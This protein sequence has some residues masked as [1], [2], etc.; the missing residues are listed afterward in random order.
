MRPIYTSVGL[1]G[2]SP[3]VPINYQEYR[4]GFNTSLGAVLTTGASLTYTVQHTYDDPNRHYHVLVSRSG[5]TA[6]MIAT[7][8]G[9][10]AGDSIIVGAGGAP[11][12][13]TFTVASVID[14][15]TLTYTVSNSGPLT[16]SPEVFTALLRVYPHSTL[17]NKTTR[18]EGVYTSPV[19][20]VRL[21]CTSHTTGYVTLIVVQAGI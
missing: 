20:G 10:V 21:I 18:S 8:H 17:V 19:T 4:A 1:V 12:D 11:F 7:D 3:W 5:T 13:G 6:T 9:L 16:A 14:A 2:T 15:N